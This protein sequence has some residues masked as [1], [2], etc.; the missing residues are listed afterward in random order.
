MTMISLIAVFILAAVA[1]PAIVLGPSIH[2]SVD[3]PSAPH[4]ES[5]LAIDPKNPAHMLASSIAVNRGDSEGASVYI[6]RDSGRTWQRARTSGAN[7]PHLAGGDP[8][9][10]FDH[11]GSAL[12]NSLCGSPDC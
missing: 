6:S 7:V 11:S 5:F 3:N 10:Y 1:S 8:M 2:V 4:A 12:F 9:V